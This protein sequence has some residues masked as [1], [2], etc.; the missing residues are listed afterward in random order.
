[1]GIFSN[2]SSNG[3]LSVLKNIKSDTE[4][5]RQKLA[6]LSTNIANQV[7]EINPKQLNQILLEHTEGLKDGKV[8]LSEAHASMTDDFKLII[9]EDEFEEIKS[10]IVNNFEAYNG[11]IELGINSL[12]SYLNEFKRLVKSTN[13]INMLTEQVSVLNKELKN[14]TK[15]IETFEI[16]Q[17]HFVEKNEQERKKY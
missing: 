17:E 15:K 6:S 3:S 9:E 7:E 11:I 14:L 4:N 16:N 8:I 1:M 12:E 5:L 13:G 10:R 2:R